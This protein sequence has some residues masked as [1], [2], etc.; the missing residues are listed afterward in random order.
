MVAS[1]SF[2]VIIFGICEGFSADTK[3]LYGYY[4]LIEG[5]AW[6]NPGTFTRANGGSK[7]YKLYGIY[8]RD[9]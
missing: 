6:Y 8:L 9:K 2:P 5:L 1:A 4:V 7:Y 3:F